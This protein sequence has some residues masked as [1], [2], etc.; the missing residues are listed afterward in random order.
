[1]TGPFSAQRGRSHVLFER[2]WFGEVSLQL[3]EQQGVGGGCQNED[4]E[5]SG[6][7]I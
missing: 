7:G 6:F 2:T 5:H 1:M 3:T 4:P